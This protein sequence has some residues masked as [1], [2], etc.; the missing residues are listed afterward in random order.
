MSKYMTLARLRGLGITVAQLSDA[1]ALELIKNVSD[2]LDALTQQVF[3]PQLEIHRTDGNKSRLTHH[4]SLLPILKVFSLNVDVDKNRSNY[5]DEHRYIFGRNLQ[6][7]SYDLTRYEISSDTKYRLLSLLAGEFPLGVENVLINGVFG[8]LENRKAFQTELS[9]ELAMGDTVVSV[10]ETSN[11]TG[12]IEVGDFVLV[13]I[14]AATGEAPALTYVDIVQS[15]SA[16]NLT[17]DAVQDQA[18][19]PVAVG[20]KV[21][22]F[23]AFPGPLVEVMDALLL[24]AWD[25][26]PWNPNGS[27]STDKRLLSEKVDNY[28]YQLESE[29]VAASRAG[30]YGL[31]TGSVRLDKVLQ[32]YC[33][34]GGFVG[35]V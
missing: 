20:V 9:A 35:Y 14:E 26:S 2:S 12:R 22:S 11:S 17:V 25:D 28:S 27:G 34:P 21:Y 10:A 3:S 5:W 24:R 4:R 13:E 6:N 33:R 30:G 18:G 32:Q 19:L 15:I 23:G 31:I 7:G 8:F 16:T 1:L 29:S